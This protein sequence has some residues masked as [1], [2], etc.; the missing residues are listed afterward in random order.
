[1][2]ERSDVTLCFL[3]EGTPGNF[4][5]A[6][7]AQTWLPGEASEHPMSFLW[8]AASLPANTADSAPSP[9]RTLAQLAV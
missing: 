6:L 7:P 3:Q 4:W 9:C 1:M 8:A 2:E 5:Q